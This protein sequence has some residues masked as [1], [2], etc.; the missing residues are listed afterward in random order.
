[1]LVDWSMQLVYLTK[2]LT[3]PLICLMRS[4][5]MI[6]LVPLKIK[7]F[8]MSYRLLKKRMLS[9]LM[10]QCISVLKMLKK[11]DSAGIV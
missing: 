11:L 6:V 4:M 1:M 10:N 2:V 8:P 7:D 9:A 5:V 3:A